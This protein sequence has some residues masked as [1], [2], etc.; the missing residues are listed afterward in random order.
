MIPLP[1]NSGISPHPADDP[2]VRAALLAV[3]EGGSWSGYHGDHLPRLEEG[4]AELH[5]VEFAYGC[6][7]G[8]FAVELALRAVGIGP[9]D[10]VLLAG[11][12]F[13]GNFR[14][15]EAIGARPV[16]I[17]IEPT[18]WC[19]DPSEIERA[20][21]ECRP[22]GV[23]VSHLHG[24]LA[25]MEAIC[26]IAVES[27]LA[28]I[29]DAC[30]ATGAIVQGR[31]AGSW[32]DA[33][34]ISFGGSKLLTAGRGGAIVTRR[35]DVLQRAKIHCEQGNH[36]FPLSEIQAALLSPQLDQLAA[37]NHRRREGARSLLDKFSRRG[38]PGR[39]AEPSGRGDASYYKL[40]WQLP[41][42]TTQD[43]RERLL[44]HVAQFKTSETSVGALLSVGEG[45]RGFAR[46]SRRRCLPVG[47]LPHSKAAAEQTV[48]IHHTHLLGDESHLEQLAEILEQAWNEPATR[49]N[50]E[51]MTS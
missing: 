37:R 7:S 23:V 33:G 21:R 35:P 46:R 34:V 15:I 40:G 14:C 45:F 36:A 30:Q 28:V 3:L 49:E 13:P 22:K 25:D 51:S 1:K 26:R 16:V 44:R 9:G 32:G 39:F 42:G 43:R 10:D 6:C 17:D 5:Q 27:H 41:E 19:I 20:L 38:I 48:L 31:V 8:T 11:Y 29:E 12:D 47:S 18:S 24:S 50:R 2:A 4:L